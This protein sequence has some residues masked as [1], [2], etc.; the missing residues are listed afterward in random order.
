MDCICIRHSVANT[1][2]DNL[3]LRGRDQVVAHQGRARPGHPVWGS[4]AAGGWGRVLE[5]S[6]S[7]RATRR[8]AAQVA[9]SRRYSSVSGGVDKKIIMKKKAGIKNIGSPLQR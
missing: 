6:L 7:A 3:A 8:S 5:S 4:T 2:G 9:G 1:D